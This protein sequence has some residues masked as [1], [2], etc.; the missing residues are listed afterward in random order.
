MILVGMGLQMI[1]QQGDRFLKAAP[2]AVIGRPEHDLPDLAGNLG[3][4]VQVHAFGG[5]HFR[6]VIPA[7]LLPACRLLGPSGLHQQEN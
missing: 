6:D 5:D 4:V 7:L 3:H 1:L 2:A